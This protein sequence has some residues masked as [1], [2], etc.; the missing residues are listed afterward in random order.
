MPFSIEDFQDLRRLLEQHPEWRAEIRRLVLTE[1]L[2][3]LPALVRGLTERLDRL[4]ERLDQLA[5]RV[6]QLAQRVDQ[7]AAVMQQL[8]SIQVRTEARLTSVEDRLGHALGAVAE[9]RYRFRGGAYFSRIARRVGAM[10]SGELADQLL[11]AVEAG[12]LREEERQGILLADLVFTAWRLDGSEDI[13]LLVEVSHGVGAEDVTRALHRAR[14]LE[15]TGRPVVPVVAGTSITDDAAETAAAAGV[16][17]VLDGHAV[18]PG[19]GA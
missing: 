11:D 9:I 7:L 17:Q 16:W 14:L 4:T 6:D 15:R 8:A 3:G 5:Q 1:E 12:V 10:D 19:A 13:Y 2:L 18:P